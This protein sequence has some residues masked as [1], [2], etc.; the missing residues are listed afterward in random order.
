MIGNPDDN[1]PYLTFI[2]TDTQTVL[3][4]LT[5]PTSQV[6]LEQPVW[7]AQTNRFLISV[8][9]VGTKLGSVDEIDPIAMQITN[10]F[11]IPSCSP[12]G[13]ALGPIQRV[14]TSCG[15]AVDGRYGTIL[16]TLTGATA[17]EIWFNPGDNRYYFG[18]AN[19]AVVDAETNSILGYLTTSGGHSIAVDSNNGDIFVPVAKVGIEVFAR[20]RK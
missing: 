11:Q 2:S 10:S 7:N 19:V 14:M 3:G 6:G 16:A 1:P 12:A 9:A 5:Y 18:S 4:K 13:L 8:P 15:T 20:V 17:D